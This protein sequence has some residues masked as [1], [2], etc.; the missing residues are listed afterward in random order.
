[1]LYYFSRGTCEIYMQTFNMIG[2][3][4]PYFKT[5]QEEN[6]LD[7]YQQFISNAVLVKPL[8]R[9]WPNQAMYNKYNV[10]VIKFT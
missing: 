1:M 6:F 4:L 5:E 9:V 2:S 3:I 8:N 10:T 7:N